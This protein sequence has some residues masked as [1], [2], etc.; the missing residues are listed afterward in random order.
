VEHFSVVSS[1]ADA[2]A[3]LDS[4]IADVLTLD[5]VLGLGRDDSETARYISQLFRGRTERV[6]REYVHSQVLGQSG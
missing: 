6:S 3:F 5:D 2:D 1:V 4:Q